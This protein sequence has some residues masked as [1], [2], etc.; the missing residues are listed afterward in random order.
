MTWVGPTGGLLDWAAAGRPI[1]GEVVSGDQH[2]VAVHPG[3]ALVGV[4]DGLGHG[5][6]A[7]ASARVAIETLEQNPGLGVEALV[8]RCHDELRRLRGVVMSIASFDA[9]RSSMTW[10]GVGN[11]EGVLVRAA[12]TAG[13]GKYARHE[14]LLLWGGVV[15]QSLPT[16]RP[17]TVELFPGDTILLAT[18]GLPTASF[19]GA[20]MNDTV[21][22]MATD[23]LGRHA[24]ATDDALVLVARYRGGAG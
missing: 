24:R 1:P 3:G 17:E 11:V 22:R 6:H 20:R 7:E 10:I 13:D 2:V 5:I 23:V 14:R 8:R 9:A 16:L 15:G 18:D 12:A 19:D 4:V 21:E